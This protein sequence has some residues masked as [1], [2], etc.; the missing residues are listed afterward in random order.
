MAAAVLGIAR[1]HVRTRRGA[2]GREREPRPKK[3]YVARQPLQRSQRK[4]AVIPL[5]PA[6]ETIVEGE[7]PEFPKALR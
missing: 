3:L 4:E 7:Y 6:H 2:F 1:R 5:L